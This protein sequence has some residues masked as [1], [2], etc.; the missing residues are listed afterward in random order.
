MK[1]NV[2]RPATNRLLRVGPS[3]LAIRDSLYAYFSLEFNGMLYC[4]VLDSFQ[5]AGDPL[6]LLHFLAL[7]AEGLW[8]EQRAYMLCT[9]G[10]LIASI[11]SWRRHRRARTGKKKKVG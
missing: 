8:A 6:F 3:K 10:R 5:I 1:E 7:C 4:F 2:N 9:K 11:R